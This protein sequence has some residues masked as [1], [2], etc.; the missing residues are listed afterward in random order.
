MGVRLTGGLIDILV[1]NTSYTAFTLSPGKRA[2]IKK[3]LWFNN[4]GGNGFLWIGATIAAAFT[5]LLPSIL[6]VNG[7]DGELG[8]D[9][10]PICGN[11][12]EGFVADTTVATLTTGDIVVQATVGAA[13]PNCR[14]IIEVEEE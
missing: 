4:T 10:I 1:A 2:V 9:E 8:E 5:Q 13:A 3:I 14:V 12:P 7:V 6:M 11:T